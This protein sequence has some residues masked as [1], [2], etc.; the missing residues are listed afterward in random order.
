VLPALPVLLV[1]QEQEAQMDQLVHQAH[2]FRFLLRVPLG[3]LEPVVQ[4]V[5][6]AA[7]AAAAA[8]RA[9]SS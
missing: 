6:A 2:F 1:Q 9:V 8:E 5:L 3:Q 4:M 7:A